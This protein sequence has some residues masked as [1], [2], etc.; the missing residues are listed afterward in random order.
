MNLVTSETSERRRHVAAHHGFTLIELL[1]V[2]AIIAILAALLLPAL[3][4][5][6]QKA[7]DINCVSNCK[8]FTLGLNMYNVESRGRLISYRDPQD[9]GAYYTL[10]MA[11]LQTNFN[12]NTSSR[13][14]PSAP[15]ILGTP[16]QSEAA[17]W[18]GAKSPRMTQ[19]Q[20]NNDQGTTERPYLW[21]P[22]TFGLLG[23]SLQAGYGINGYA[24][25]ANPYNPSGTGFETESAIKN[26]SLTPYFEDATFAEGN[27]NAQP[28]VDND[29]G[30]WNLY[31]G[32]NNGMGR[33]AIAR[34]GGK[35][36]G[37]APTSIPASPRPATLPGLS[38][39]AFAD[40]HAEL[41][42]IDNLWQLYWNKLWVPTSRP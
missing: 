31:D 36:P 34:H 37:A 33:V 17:A 2:I 18:Y 23:T 27:P 11:R 32:Y 4:K 1:V 42:K 30:T 12:L 16:G 24:E 41:I 22:P 25:S 26:P 38:D 28:A 19:S 8:Q 39:V 21:N 29:G 6:K 10:W 3:A 5:A 15:Q 35:G 20:G 14:C 40:G 9:T 7:K 13:C